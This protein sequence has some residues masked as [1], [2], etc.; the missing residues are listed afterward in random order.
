MVDKQRKY[1]MAALWE[2]DNVVRV[3]IKLLKSTDSDIIEYLEDKPKQATI[4]KHYGIICS[5]KTTAPTKLESQEVE[6][7]RSN[8]K[9]QFQL[10]N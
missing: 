1:A 5:P 3:S 2:K 8:M 10:G 7:E 9:K 4:K 6:N